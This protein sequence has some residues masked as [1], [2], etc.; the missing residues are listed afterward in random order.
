[1]TKNKLQGR[2]WKI[3]KDREGVC[4]WKETI[5]KSFS[6]AV[7]TALPK[8]RKQILKIKDLW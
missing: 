4:V 1:M 8:N 3:E 6:V 7:I 2:G 5:T